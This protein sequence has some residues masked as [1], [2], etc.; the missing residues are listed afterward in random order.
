MAHL[1]QRYAAALIELSL[2]ADMLDRHIEQ[3]AFI[4]DALQIGQAEDF[5]IHP[6]IADSVKRELVHRLFAEKI[7]G[8][9]MG[10][11]Y[12]AIEKSREALILPVLREYIDTANRRKGKIPATVVSA[13]ELR[14]E[15]LSALQALL[16]KKLG[17]QV[18]LAARHDP[19]V[20]GGLYIYAEGRLIDRTVRTQL[21]NMKKTI[22]DRGIE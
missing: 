2:E 5:L 13:V 22:R 15:Q 8:E 3:A 6:G 7:S 21:S 12:L 4:Q 10:F 1:K 11:L 19:A 16:S 14:R 18:D 9:F 20:I 17:K